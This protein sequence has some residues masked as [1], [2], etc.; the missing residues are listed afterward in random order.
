MP[1]FYILNAPEFEPIVETARAAGMD[2]RP[3]GD[4]L[5]ATSTRPEVVLSHAHTGVRPSIWFA[6][7]TGGLDGRI[8]RFDHDELCLADAD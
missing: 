8:V 3:V 5:E 7:L 6:S 1:T 2:V 4:Y